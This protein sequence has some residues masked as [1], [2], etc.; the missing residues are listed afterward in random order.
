MFDSMIASYIEY[1]WQ[2]QVRE[3]I[4]AAGGNPE[5]FTFGN[6]NKYLDIEFSELKR[7]FGSLD[8][9]ELDI[10]YRKDYNEKKK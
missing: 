9:S 6:V 3:K 4:K 10:R 1:L 2:E 7:I 8:N 5:I